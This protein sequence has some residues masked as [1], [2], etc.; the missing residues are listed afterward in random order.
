MSAPLAAIHLGSNTIRLL[1]AE[2]DPGRGLRPTWGEQTVV[3]LGEG[4]TERG[5]LAPNDMDRALAAVRHYRDRA[6]ALGAPGVP[7]PSARA[8]RA[9][10][11]GART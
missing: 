10:S 2:I 4:L 6:R 5:T 7:L 11:P 3:R 9:W 1:V 8:C